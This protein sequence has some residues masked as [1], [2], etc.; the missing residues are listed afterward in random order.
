MPLTLPNA[1]AK[2]MYKSPAQKR[3]LN[4]HHGMKA[5]QWD[6]KYGSDVQRSVNK[7][8]SPRRKGFLSRIASEGYRA[9]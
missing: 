2:V 4:K 6:Y 8:S 3:F 1:P 9:S 7:G 5:R